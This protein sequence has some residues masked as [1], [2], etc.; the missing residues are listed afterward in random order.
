MIKNI[1]DFLHGI[2]TEEKKKLNAYELK[3]GPTIGKM[4]EGLTSSILEKSIP[5][6]LNLQIVG[7]M[8]HDHK[9]N[10]SGEIDCMLVKGNGEQIPFTNSYKW[11]VRDVLAIFE[12]KKNLF[13]DNLADSFEHLREVTQIYCSYIDNSGENAVFNVEP[14]RR[15][16]KEI[17]GQLPDFELEK[18]DSTNDFIY[19]T[20]V[21][22][23]ISP[24]RI[25]IGYNSYKT[26]YNMRKAMQEFLQK[27]TTNSEFGVGILP[28][29]C[30]CG[31]FSL[32]KLNGQPYS[33]IMQDD[34]WDFYASSNEKPILLLLELIWTKLTNQLDI[35]LPWGEDLT[36]EN[37]A[38]LLGG[39]IVSKGELKCWNY[40]FFDVPNDLLKDRSPSKEW[41]PLFVDA[42]KF[43]V[44]KIL[45][46][47]GFIDVN[48]RQFTKI[49]NGNGLN[50][51]DFID[52][53]IKTGFVVINANRLELSTYE[54]LCMTLPDGRYAVGEDNSG[55]FTR[56]IEKQHLDLSNKRHTLTRQKLIRTWVV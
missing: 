25:V 6:S 4:Y 49:L 5:E 46:K 40:R 23:Q 33:S 21:T 36:D 31:D 18:P 22:E 41:E 26:E 56:W 47:H 16:F 51:N 19:H 50:K 54:C 7:G 14:A 43:I 9:G 42:E 20:L 11:H 24:I 55:R 53:L 34:Y 12:V 37:L 27:N 17:T 2:I 52:L 48:D 30:I 1:S 3:H 38:R 29:L 28:Q 45:C 35:S 10:L 39:K 8:I 13:S 15:A 32:I 44:F